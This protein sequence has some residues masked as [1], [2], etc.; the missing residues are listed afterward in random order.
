VGR[1]PCELYGRMEAE[2]G[3]AVRK[4]LR[5]AAKR[6]DRQAQTPHRA[7]EVT[8]GVSLRRRNSLGL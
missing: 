2:I 8:I 5:A 6:G 4:G 7:E 1:C 3:S